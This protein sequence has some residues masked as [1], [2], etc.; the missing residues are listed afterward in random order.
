MKKN[1]TNPTTQFKLLVL[2]ICLFAY[3]YCCSQTVDKVRLGYDS[4]KTISKQT[5]MAVSLNGKYLAFAFQ[6]RTIKIFDVINNKF[7]ARLQAPVAQFND[8]KLTNQGDRI[9]FV[10]QSSL[11]VFDWR[12]KTILK[13]FE[14]SKQVTRTAFLDSQNLIAV[15]MQDGHISVF[16]IDLLLEIFNIKIK[17][18][19]VSVLDLSP[20]GKR[21]VAGAIESKSSYPLNLFDIPSKK[22]LAVS[23]KEIY[24]S[25]FFNSNGTGIITSGLKIKSAGGKIALMTLSLGAAAIAFRNSTFI[26]QLDPITLIRS[27]KIMKDGQFANITYYQQGLSYN[28]KLLLMTST[29]SFDVVDLINNNVVFTTTE[30][31]K[32]MKFSTDQIGVDFERIY[33]IGE[34]GKFFINTYKNNINQIYDAQSNSIVGYIFVDSNEDYSVIARDGRIDGTKDALSKVYWTSKKSNERTLLD[35]RYEIGFTPRLFSELINDTRM[36]QVSEFNSDDVIDKVPQLVINEIANSPLLAGSQITSVKKNIG[37]DVE[38]AKNSTEVTEVRL[39][40]NGKLQKIKP[41]EGKSNYHFDVQLTTS[42]GEENYFS[43]SAQSKVGIESEKIKFTVS[44]KGSTDDKP[45]MFIFSVGINQYKNPKYNLNYAQ[46][47]ADAF[48]NSLKQIAN[49]LF[50]EIIVTNIRNEYATRENIIQAFTL[51]QKNALEQDVLVFYYA[52]HGV[53][54]GPTAQD[55]DFYIV[56]TGITQ[57]YGKDDTLKEKA[58][59]ASELKKLSQTI[60]AQKQIFI[61]DA[62][63]S[64]GALET[65][66]QRGAEEE[67]AIAQLARSTGSFWI[68]ASGTSQF[69]TE[70]EKLGHGAFTYSLL[71]GISGKADGNGDKKLTIKELSIYIENRVPEISEQYKGSPQFPSS[72]SFGNDFPLVIYK[73]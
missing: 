7:V 4:T 26:Y 39:F 70:F 67:K 72:Y 3:N 55:R 47:D 45:R 40:Q 19:G 27:E 12:N 52:G 35:S 53:M 50:K 16:N 34:S 38:V 18:G 63:Q 64:A 65:L 44:Y 37:I 30:E 46:A 58:I 36:A 33:R 25:A 22:L 24:T 10:S 43:I 54:S 31:N 2:L 73:D 68:T 28:D 69:A 49:G 29:Q 6:D 20:D 62:C 51:I 71:E 42:F 56:P 1:I 32:T 17:G 15:G 57:L 23:E 48:Q 41:N 14:L 21:I 59:S 13:S 5:G 9:I 60:N 61:F 66:S 8:F 11:I